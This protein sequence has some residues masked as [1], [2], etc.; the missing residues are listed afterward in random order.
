VLRTTLLE[1]IAPAVAA[2]TLGVVGTFTVGHAERLS[3]LE[4]ENS[5]GL[6]VQKE[7]VRKVDNLTRI[8][9]KVDTKIEERAKYEQR[10]R[11]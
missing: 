10:T 3:V 8:M 7:L 4:T 1:Y 5:T 2:A 11:Q 9:V 6:E